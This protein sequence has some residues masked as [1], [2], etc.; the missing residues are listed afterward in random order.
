LAHRVARPP[1]RVF[2]KLLSKLGYWEVQPKPSYWEVR[3]HHNYYREVV[4]LARVHASSGG[5]VID[6]GANETEVLQQLDWFG[7]RVALD[8]RSVPP[9]PGIET[10]VMNF[11]TYQPASEFDLVICLQV[12]EHLREPAIF[13]RKLLETGRTI[14]I[15]VPYKWPAGKSKWHV[16]DPVDEAKLEMW[17][18]RKPV[19][20]SVIADEN[21]RLVA[22]YKNQVEKGDK[23]NY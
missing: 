19:E 23:S 4:R 3:R 10:V 21:E 12:L 9:Q 14:I 20:V 1:W 2:T 16:Q 7:R 5:Q 11:M 15:S 17:T 22:V 13:A 6:V 8:R 18:Q